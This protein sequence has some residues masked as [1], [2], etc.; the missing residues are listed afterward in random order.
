MP[1]N[2]SGVYSIPLGTEGV[3]DTTIESNKYNA[4]VLDVQLDLNTPRP[5]V[6]GGTGA[7]DAGT[8]MAKLGGERMGEVVTNYDSHIF[9][10]GS[11]YSATTATGSPFS[12][13]A[14]SGISYSS[15]VVPVSGIPPNLNVVVEARDLTETSEPGTLWVRR[16]T[17]GA[18][19]A[20]T[21]TAGTSGG[22]AATIG[23][24]PTGN[25]GATNVQ[26]AINELELE[27]APILSPNFTGTPTS[28]GTIPPVDNNSTRLATTAWYIAQAS[29]ATP[30]VAGGGGAIGSSTRFARADHVHP[31]DNSWLN[32]G[33]FVG[34]ISVS[35]ANPKIIIQK[36]STGQEA[37]FEG[38]T[39]ANPRWQVVMGNNTTESANAGSDWQLRAFLD[40]GTQT[41][42]TPVLVERKTGWVSIA[43]DTSGPKL[44]LVKSQNG[45]NSRL[46]GYLNAFQRWGLSLGNVE[47]ESSGDAGSNFEIAAFTDG[48]SLKS[49]ALSI[50]RSDSQ[51]QIAGD[52]LKPGG[53]SW[54]ATSDARIKNVLRD[55]DRGL[56][57]IAKVR[58]VVYTYK[59]NDVPRPNLPS[60]HAIMAAAGT[61][62]AGLIAQELEQIMPEMVR[63]QPGIIDGAKVDDQRV[64]V[65]TTPLIYALIN[66]V[67]ELKARVEVLENP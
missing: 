5:I 15:D 55:Y 1:R 38:R 60:P 46:E 18:W 62:F 6:A 53:G 44:R 7:G 40:N 8:A 25:I 35:Y 21:A 20:W 54:T 51:L 26:G 33:V 9:R 57:D 30:I 59:G 4:F 29:A 22:A 17:A 34:Q 10:A 39:G 66:A 61:Q 24:Q 36:A 23:S 45:A 49:I 32:G 67:K 58:P 2:G 11:F 47:T 41:T 12:G 37:I 31:A 3:P 52:A 65:D 48:G 16:K 13:H 19:G 43:G 50:R 14:F 63:R 28:S 42:W 56:D 64:I 27:K